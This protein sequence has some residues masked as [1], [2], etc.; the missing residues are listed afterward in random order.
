MC[1]QFAKISFTCEQKNIH[2]HEK[3]SR[4]NPILGLE[5][6][7]KSH[8]TQFS[9]PL[10]AEAVEFDCSKSEHHTTQFSKPLSAE[11][12]QFDCSKSDCPIPHNSPN[13]CQPRHEASVLTQEKVYLIVCE[14][15]AKL[16]RCDKALSSK[17]VYSLKDYKHNPIS[18]IGS[19]LKK[20]FLIFNMNFLPITLEIETFITDDNRKSFCVCCYVC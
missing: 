4:P 8:T 3:F 12:V 13:H 5:I 20:S 10:S 18:I 16:S 15:K 11:A 9:K 14:K 17:Y 19:F 6:T 1:K 2:L 7:C